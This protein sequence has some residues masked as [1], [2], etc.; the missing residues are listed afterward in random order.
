MNNNVLQFLEAAAQTLNAGFV[1]DAPQAE[2]VGRMFGVDGPLL[3][4]G[5]MWRFASLPP[6]GQA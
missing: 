2:Y 1:L 5:M 3:A 4:L 6:A